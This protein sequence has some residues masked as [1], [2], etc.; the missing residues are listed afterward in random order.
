MRFIREVVT[1]PP[2]CV[3]ELGMDKSASRVLNF[4][5]SSELV[6]RCVRDAEIEGSIPS[7]PT[8]LF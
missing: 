8:D 7:S 5:E 4:S 6:S 2:F 1:P 3:A